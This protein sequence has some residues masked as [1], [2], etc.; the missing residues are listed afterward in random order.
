MEL[1]VA[2]TNQFPDSIGGISVENTY[3]GEYE[4]ATAYAAYDND[5]E[6]PMSL[7]Y[8]DDCYWEDEGYHIIQ[9]EELCQ[10]TEIDESDMAIDFL[11]T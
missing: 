7:C 3:W 2:F 6:G 8:S 4:E 11:L 9:F 5:Y 1:V 10:I